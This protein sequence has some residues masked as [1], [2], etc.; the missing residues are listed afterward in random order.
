[1][2]FSNRYMSVRLAAAAPSRARSISSVASDTM[3][4]AVAS[5]S[6][7]RNDQARL[8]TDQ[9]QRTGRGIGNNGGQAARHCL[10]QSIRRAFEAGSKHEELGCTE[11]GYRIFDE[12]DPV[13]SRRNAEI[14]CK[15]VGVP[16]AMVLRR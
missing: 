8:V 7:T 13:N 11:I 10:E 3:A 2:A 4:E 14:V 12:A 6:S 1:M 5:T 15:G 9:L 16:R